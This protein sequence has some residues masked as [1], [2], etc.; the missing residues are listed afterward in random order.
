M[1]YRNKGLTREFWFTQQ[2]ELYALNLIFFVL[3]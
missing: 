2:V 3:L 1:S